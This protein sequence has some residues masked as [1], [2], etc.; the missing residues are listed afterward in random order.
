M[1]LLQLYAACMRCTI[2]SLSIFSLGVAVFSS[3][4]LWGSKTD[5][6]MERQSS[7]RARARGA[8]FGGIHALAIQHPTPYI[9]GLR[10]TSFQEL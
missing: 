9:L 7:R 10:N 1:R 6:Q 4:D 2:L 3:Q 5:G 8:Q